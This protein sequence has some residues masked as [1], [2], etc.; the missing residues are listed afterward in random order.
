MLN[1]FVLIILTEFES[2]FYNPNNP[3]NYY[4]DDA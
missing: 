2:N 1:L 4:K 3:L